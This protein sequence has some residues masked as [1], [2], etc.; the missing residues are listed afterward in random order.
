MI[1]LEKLNEAEVT[2]KHS[3]AMTDRE[4]EFERLVAKKE[5]Q[6]QIARIKIAQMEG[7]L[8]LVYKSLSWKITA[9]LRRYGLRLPR[10]LKLVNRL[11]GG[12]SPVEESSYHKIARGQSLNAVK[13]I[14]FPGG[15]IGLQLHLYYVDLLDEVTA[16]IA[17]IPFQ[18]S[19]YVSV[20]DECHIEPV[21]SKLSAIKSAQYCMVKAVSNRG[22][23]LAPLVTIF[24]DELMKHDFICHIHTKKSLY[25]SKEQDSWRRHFY[26]NLLGTPATI[27]KIFGIFASHKDVGI[28]YPETH[29]M[30]P[31]WAHSWLGNKQ[32]GH[33]LCNRFGV[34]CDLSGF[35]DAP[36]GTMFWARTAAL[37]P[38]LATGFTIADFPEESGQT[39]GTLA[40]TLER[41][42]VPIAMTQGFTFCEINTSRNE[43]S[44]SFGSRNIFQ[45]WAKNLD[46]L[47]S[48]IH[49]HDLITFDIF[50]TLI[51]RPL[52]DPD[53]VLDL[54]SIEVERDEGI[55]NFREI[56]KR[57]E[58]EIR[59]E[60]G[61]DS[62]AGINEIYWRIGSTLKLDNTVIDRLCSTEID[63]EFRLSLPRPEVVE[64][65]RFARE[66]G[67][68]VVLMSDM[69]LDEATVR[70]LLKKN[71]IEGYDELFL[72]SSLGVRK[73]NAGMWLK[74][75]EHYPGVS[76]LHIGD[77]EHS[78]VQLPSDMGIPVY[79]VM[80]PKNIFNNSFVGRELPTHTVYKSIADSALLGMSVNYLFNNP[81]GMHYC[82][83]DY[84]FSDK[85][86]FGYAVIGPVI[87]AYIL[88][89]IRSSIKD[90]VSKILFLAREG[91]LL[92]QIFDMIL[93]YKEVAI[94]LNSKIESV[95]LLASRRATTVP[96]ID[97]VN[98][99]LGLLKKDYNGTLYNIMESRFGLDQRYLEGKGVVN[100][101]IELPIDHEKV[102]AVVR[103]HF[104]AILSNALKERECNLKYLENMGLKDVMGGIALS[105]LGYSGN[106]QKALSK[107]LGTS[108]RGYYFATCL[109]VADN[110]K[111]GNKFHGYFAEE[112]DQVITESS[113]Y[114]YSL[115]LESIL[116]SP[117]GQLACFE[118]CGDKVFPIFEKTNEQF[119]DLNKIHEG[120]TTYCS[121]MLKYFGRYLLDFEPDRKIT[122]YFFG[123][124]ISEH[125]VDQKLLSQLKVEDKYC[126]DGDIDAL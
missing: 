37:R 86:G 113:V 95:Y 29:E 60:K 89:L 116:T 114:R 49:K 87:F 90:N 69:Y 112:D 7:Q 118:D 20:A 96:A 84:I 12:K 42:L 36:M 2:A 97:N 104:H 101:C 44:V 8:N 121:D 13:E 71:G 88:W 38:L 124:V 78:D 35:L 125:K 59:N 64:A 14:D 61:F 5:Q 23:D 107:L 98:D 103:E 21:R 19:L 119:R 55:K 4:I 63:I 34:T 65:F 39:D 110:D 48:T 85:F 82:K 28:V 58:A 10:L 45:Y 79:H 50:D 31:Y 40:H 126:S 81:F 111:L 18:Y 43:Y 54:L 47:K 15:T 22:R 17:N 109:D 3:P 51:T 9:P 92:K 102:T 70:T 66:N 73:D 77:N 30:L 75:L 32:L 74:L 1:N 94:R 41:M 57:A 106:I 72:S 122:E 80:S 16:Y 62:D 76:V 33:Q 93:A 100:S 24:A 108:L 27:C 11:F 91:Y 6:L 53:S 46:D 26:E 83:G 105:D 99:A 52:L 25:T 117:D 115:V 68:R 56:R 67:K 123:K 120:I